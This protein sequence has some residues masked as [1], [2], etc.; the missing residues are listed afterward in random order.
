MKEVLRTND[1]V[2][3]SY[4]QS[5]LNDAGIEGVVLDEGMSTLYG[6]GLPFI[7]RRLMVVDEDEAEALRLLAEALPEEE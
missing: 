4:A 3:L 2:R 5:L 6:G 1:P 7:K